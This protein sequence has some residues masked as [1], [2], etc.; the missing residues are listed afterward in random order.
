MM[1]VGKIRSAAEQEAHADAR[2]FD[3]ARKSDRFRTAVSRA[4]GTTTPGG[5]PFTYDAYNEES[6]V[7]VDP[8]DT[9]RV[10][11]I[12]METWGPGVGFRRIPAG[13]KVRVLVTPETHAPNTAGSRVAHR[14]PIGS[15]PFKDKG[16]TQAA[17]SR[18][19]ASTRPTRV[20][21]P[22]PDPEGVDLS[23][24]KPVDMT[25]VEQMPAEEVATMINFG[26]AVKGVDDTP[27]PARIPKW[28]TYAGTGAAV[29]GGYAWFVSGKRKR[30]RNATVAG[31]IGALVGYLFSKRES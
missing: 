20:T 21:F 2:A 6:T 14:A 26:P 4:L 8:T 13:N 22:D 16:A 12:A 29:W 31:S 30:V 3:Q 27:K 18:S 5:I 19:V 28:A 10:R 17:Q 11:A 7:I 15:N 25:P 1:Y 9:A 24:V 23:D